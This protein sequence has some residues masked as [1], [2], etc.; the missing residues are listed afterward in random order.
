MMRK[1]IHNR[2]QAAMLIPTFA[3]PGG[4]GIGDVMAVIIALNF[5]A[6]L[7]IGALQDLPKN[8]TGLDDRNGK[9]DPSPYNAVSSMALE[10]R[11]LYMHPDWVPGCTQEDYALFN[12]QSLVSALNSGP[13][14]YRVVGGLK[15]AIL[16]RAFER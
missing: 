5:C 12:A 16:W 4:H 15:E 10:P 11:L 9:D 6:K 7:K 14:N 2:R 8:R 1:Q 13:V 3:L